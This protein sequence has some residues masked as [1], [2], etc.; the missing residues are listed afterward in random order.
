LSGD[1]RICGGDEPCPH[2]RL[3]NHART[4]FVRVDVSSACRVGR[5]CERSNRRT[6]ASARRAAGRQRHARFLVNGMLHRRHGRPPGANCERRTP[7][8]QSGSAGGALGPGGG[9][10]KTRL[11][12]RASGGTARPSL[13]SSCCT[14]RMGF[15]RVEERPTGSATCRRGLHRGRR[16][17]QLRQRDHRRTALERAPFR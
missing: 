12:R 16:C 3:S 15:P 2:E 8:N 1:Q 4:E 5:R 14:L 10:D 9:C 11:R 6:R 13:S 17:L 7:W